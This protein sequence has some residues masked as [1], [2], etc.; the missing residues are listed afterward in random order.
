MGEVNPNAKCFCNEATLES[1]SGYSLQIIMN[2]LHLQQIFHSSIKK[3][4]MASLEQ[5][6]PV[7]V[8]TAQLSPQNI[9]C[10]EDS[11]LGTRHKFRIMIL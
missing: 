4:F 3:P 7:P 10:L 2:S 9:Y 11:H 1:K 6:F 5:L 8:S